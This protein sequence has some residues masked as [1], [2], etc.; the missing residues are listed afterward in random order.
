MVRQ[1]DWYNPGVIRGI[2]MRIRLMLWLV[3]ALIVYLNYAW[4]I[5]LIEQFLN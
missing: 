1:K 5:Q 3:L 2:R 4:L